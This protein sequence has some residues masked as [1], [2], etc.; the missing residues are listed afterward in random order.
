[1]QQELAVE[2]DAGHSTEAFLPFYRK[3]TTSPYTSL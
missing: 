2:T 3:N 1:M